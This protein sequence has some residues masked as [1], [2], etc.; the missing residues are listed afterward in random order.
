MSIDKGKLHHW[1]RQ[2]THIKTWHLAL[3]FL[4]LATASVFLLRNNNLQMVE[5][6]RAVLEA[7]QEGGDVE[8]ALQ[9]LRTYMARH[10]NTR[11]GEPIQLKYTYERIAQDRFAKAA[12]SGGAAN[13]A[14]YQQAQAECAR[15]NTV[16]YAQCVIDRTGNLAPG[17]NP[18]VNVELP[19]VAMFSY[20]FY[21]PAWSPDLAGFVLL[22][23]VLTLLIIIVRV[24]VE[25]I[26]YFVLRRHR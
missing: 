11:M 26:V 10:M 15:S 5:H 9:E 20:I 24:A 25:R 8:K 4:F 22:L 14:A 16:A 12:E 21:S 23:A 7:D 3:L 13:A 1:W 2:L 6:R 19:D 17:A 18:I